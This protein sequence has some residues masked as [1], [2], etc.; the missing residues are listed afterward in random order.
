MYVFQQYSVT[1]INI[2]SP[3]YGVADKI[4]YTV[5]SCHCCV[6]SQDSFGCQWITNISIHQK[7]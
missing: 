7:L 6:G 4:I 3:E 2:K 5:Q 1:D